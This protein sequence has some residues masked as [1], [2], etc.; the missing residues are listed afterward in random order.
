VSI[1]RSRSNSSPVGRSTVEI[2]IHL[3]NG[4]MIVAHA[5]HC[6]GDVVSAGG[7]SDGDRY[8]VKTPI[9]SNCRLATRDVAIVAVSVGSF[10]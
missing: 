1:E 5:V 3:V 4:K 2:N 10:Y 8:T 9:C 7:G 6:D